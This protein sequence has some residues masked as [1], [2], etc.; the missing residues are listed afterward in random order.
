M[1]I[2]ARAR[3][4]KADAFFDINV[5]FELS[6]LRFKPAY[7]LVLCRQGLADTRFAPIALPH[8]GSASA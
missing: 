1:P 7:A 2:D 8:T 6:I 5:A 3:V 4:K